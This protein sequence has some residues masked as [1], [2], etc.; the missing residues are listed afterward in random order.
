MPYGFKT[1]NS[2]RVGS[3]A[4]ALELPDLHS[5]EVHRLALRALLSSWAAPGC[6]GWD[7]G[8]LR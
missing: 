7:S 5:N 6:G 3:P 4:P 1:L 8:H 2:I